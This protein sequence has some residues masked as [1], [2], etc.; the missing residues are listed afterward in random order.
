VPI[1]NFALSVLRSYAQILFSGSVW[2][3]FLL[4]LATCVMPFS[5]AIGVL[6]TVSALLSAR[7]FHLEPDE[8]HSGGYGYNAL[9]CGLGIG[10]HCGLSLGT[11]ALAV[12]CGVLCVLL[13]AALRASL[14]KLHLPML[15]I[16]FVVV[17]HIVL[18]VSGPAGLDV[19]ATTSTLLSTEGP[20]LLRGLGALFFLPYP[21]VG[22]LVLFAILFHSRIAAMLAT[23]GFLCAYF[24]AIYLLRIPEETFVLIVSYN[25]AFSAVALG[26]V[27]FVPSASSWL[28]A[29]LSS[30]VA[31]VLCAGLFPIH[32]RLGVPLLVVPFNV[33]VFLFLLAFRQRMKDLHPKSVDLMLATPEDNLEY[34][35]ARLLR[36]GWSQP[37]R[38]QLPIRGTWLCTQ[39]KDGAHTHKDRWRHAWDFEVSGPDGSTFRTDGSRPEHYHCFRLPVLAA[40]AG[41]VVRVEQDVPDNLVGTMNLKQNWGNVVLLYHA[42]GLYSLYAHLSRGSAKVRV[43]QFV[44]AGEVLGLCGSSGRSPRPHLHFH[45]QAT[46]DLGSTTLPCSFADAITVH[47]ERQVVHAALVPREKDQVRNLEPDEERG[48]FLSAFLPGMGGQWRFNLGDREEQIVCEVDLYGQ[49]LLRSLTYGTVLRYVMTDD[50]FTTYDLS[51]SH[52]SALCLLRLALPRIPLESSESLVFSDL[53]PGRLVRSPGLQLFHDFL[54]PWRAQ[55]GVFLTY[56]SR[57]EGALLE[58]LG[59]LRP[60]GA[61]GDPEP[62]SGQD[63]KHIDKHRPESTLKTRISLARGLGVVRISV[64]KRGRT[65]LAERILPEKPSLLATEETKGPR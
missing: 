22:A 13:S 7:L 34:L 3:G 23:T 4:F 57:R 14:G 11:L 38:M 54:A 35:R 6:C 18:A 30:V 26:G 15:S 5:A 27:W 29:M 51:G 45:L 10:H 9:L 65:L 33:T 2:V 48:S 31:T 52:R 39:G 63:P 47:E 17:Y 58:V 44:Q 20:A 42:P 8:Q 24:V 50:F 53:L 1:W 16:P 40:A 55:D 60:M 62:G 43:G 59:E 56:V 19:P 32:N 25:A 28:V 37:V 41:T 21:E 46:Q 49:P 64:T 61:M 36:F 12:A